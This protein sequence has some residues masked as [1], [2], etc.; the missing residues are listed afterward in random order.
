MIFAGRLLTGLGGP[1]GISRRYIADHVSLKDRLMASSHFITAGLYIYIICS[2][3]VRICLLYST[4][5]Y[6]FPNTDHPSFM[7]P[8]YLRIVYIKL[9][10]YILYRCDGSGMWATSSLDTIHQI[11]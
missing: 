1:R 6:T 4:Y 8:P 11:Y 7:Y 9:Y 10:S 5:I 3:Y 2:V